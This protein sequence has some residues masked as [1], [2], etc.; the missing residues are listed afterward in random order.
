[1]TV[2]NNDDLRRRLGLVHR[3]L[4]YA[5]QELRIGLYDT[6]LARLR[7][8]ARGGIET[9]PPYENL[10]LG[11]SINLAERLHAAESALDVVR[12]AVFQG[13]IEAAL[14]VIEKE[15]P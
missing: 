5:Q 6:V 10:A 11:T 12:Y 7:E 3:E 13:A 14:D 2:S 9:K 4:M 15:L 1:M 8:A